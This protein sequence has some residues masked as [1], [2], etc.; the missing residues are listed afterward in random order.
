MLPKVLLQVCI[1]LF[2]QALQ[3][4]LPCEN[5]D[6]SGLFWIQ[7]DYL[8]WQVQNNQ[9]VIPL[10]I[11]QPVSN[12][13]FEVVLGGKKLKNN[14]HS[15]ADF[16]LGYWFDPCKDYAVEARY[17]FLDKQSE[18]SSIKTDSNGLPRLRVP[19]FNVV[20][21]TSTS[22]ALSRPGLNIA[23]A[24][25]KTSN[26]MQGAEINILKSLSEKSFNCF[27]GFRYFQFDDSLTFST[28]SPLIGTPSI[29]RNQDLF[30][31][32]NYFFGAQIGAFWQKCFSSFFIK[33]K[34]QLA[35][36]GMYQKLSIDGKFQTDEFLGPPSLLTF[37]GGYFAEPTNI[38]TYQK[39]KF[40]IIPEL[41]IDL[42][43][44]ITEHLSF[45]IGYTVLYV[46]QVLRASKQMSE[47]INPSQSANIPFT[48]TPFLVGKA[49]PKA[50]LK[51]SNLWTQGL[52]LGIDAEF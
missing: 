3:A 47:K 45:H 19:Y 29:Y 37:P 31:T 52:N 12:G 2:I 20:T 30:R 21:N 1:V 14:W 17:F 15:G 32:H 38:G 11:D 40:S 10:V 24:T 16:H 7:T 25:L 28:S 49:A 46:T 13:P 41:N 27:T 18:Q 9:K 36:G 39:T 6:T 43:Y 42:G 5:C 51:S 26:K 33:I 34:G 35:L 8:Y 4:N 23:E 50:K 22:V 48:P 44:Q